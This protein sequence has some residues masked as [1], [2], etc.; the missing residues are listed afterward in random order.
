VNKYYKNC[1]RILF[2]RELTRENGEDFCA[3]LEDV[4]EDTFV[5]YFQ[6]TKQ[7]NKEANNWIKEQ[8]SKNRICYLTSDAPDTIDLF[9]MPIEYEL[10]YKLYLKKFN[11]DSGQFMK[12]N[13]FLNW[14]E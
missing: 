11:R 6:Y 7:G 3:K 4:L 8:Q 12:I 5:K 2:E 14:E 1:I 9:V 10:F 13:G